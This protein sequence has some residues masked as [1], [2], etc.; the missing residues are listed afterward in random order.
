MARTLGCVPSAKARSA[1]L[2]HY[3]SSP[4]FLNLHAFAAQIYLNL[5]LNEIYVASSG[6]E[7]LRD[8]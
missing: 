5:Q 1:D 4:K 3:Q 7:N 2:G 6:V 8:V